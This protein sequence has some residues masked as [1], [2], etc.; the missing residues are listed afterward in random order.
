M[1]EHRIDVCDPADSAALSPL[2]LALCRAAQQPDIAAF[3]ADALALLRERVPFDAGLWGAGIDSDARLHQVHTWQVDARILD[4]I[5][6]D[7]E[8][9]VVPLRCC[10]QPGVAHVFDSDTL[11]AH[12]SAAWVPS[13]LGYEQLLAIVV[14]DATTGLLGSLGLLRRQA[15]PAFDASDCRWLELLMPHLLQ[16]LNVAHLSHLQ[17]VRSSSLPPLDRLAITDACGVVHLMEPG[18]AE[19][20]REQ[21]PQWSGP[22]LPD[23]VL[24]D[25]KPV[26][27][28]RKGTAA[29]LV[30]EVGEAAENLLVR[31]R[32]CSAL[33]RL[34]PQER[35]VSTAYAQG[36]SHKEVARA[37]GVTP[38]T[39][40]H[41]LRRV[42]AK[43]AVDDKA[44]LAQRLTE[45]Q[46]GLVESR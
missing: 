10:A 45:S 15:E 8:H 42:Y 28:R 19:L 30:V 37:L 38:A 1:T 2:L 27:T 3:Q 44:A 40:R 17:Q 7:V 35:A 16:M 22:C 46:P 9:N 5:N 24:L 33:D 12:P 41:H 25:P 23:S 14:I 6:Q 26:R 39:V 32:R 20:L 13:E 34:S 21:W 43:L 31:V 18:F 4:R 29:A 36:N 11:R